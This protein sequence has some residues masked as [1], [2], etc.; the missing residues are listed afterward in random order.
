LHVGE[1]STLTVRLSSASS[2]PVTVNYFVT[3]NGRNRRVRASYFTV[4]GTPGEVTVPAGATS[5]TFNLTAT[6][7]ARRPK[8]VSIYLSYGSGYT[9]GS[10]GRGATITISR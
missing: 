8:N 7:A 10:S 2:S 3:G 4:S 6:G 9:L 1:S 5:A